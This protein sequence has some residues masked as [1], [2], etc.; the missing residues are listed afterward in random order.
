[1]RLINN[2]GILNKAN[3]FG[4][5]NDDIQDGTSLSSKSFVNMVQYF[6]SHLRK[7]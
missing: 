5:C 6:S 3:S 7:L 1:M 2:L 4:Y